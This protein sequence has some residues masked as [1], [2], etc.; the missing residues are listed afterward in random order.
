LMDVPNVNS[1]IPFLI[2][3]T[4]VFATTSCSCALTGNAKPD[5]AAYEDFLRT[6]YRFELVV[7]VSNFDYRKIDEKTKTDIQSFIDRSRKYRRHYIWGKMVLINLLAN[8]DSPPTLFGPPTSHED[9]LKAVIR[10]A[11]EDIPLEMEKDGIDLDYKAIREE[12]WKEILAERGEGGAKGRS[13]PPE[14][15]SSAR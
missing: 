11:R 9:W 6:Y 2:A 5:T 4:L 3:F 14:Y 8:G 7:L 13:E 12:V 10:N 1:I 15:N